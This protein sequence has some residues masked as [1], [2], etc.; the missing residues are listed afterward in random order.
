[1]NLTNPRWLTYTESDIFLFCYDRC[2]LEI[3]AGLG[4]G[5]VLGWGLQN[6]RTAGQVLA[7]LKKV[8][9][10]A[11]ILHPLGGGGNV[12]RTITV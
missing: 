3:T 8:L 1:M 10:S 4:T 2:Q 6:G 5:R 9:W 11:Q 7:M 12:H